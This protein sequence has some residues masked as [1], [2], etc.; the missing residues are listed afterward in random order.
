MKRKRIVLVVYLLLSNS[1][2]FCQAGSIEV[3]VSDTVKLKV[4]KLEYSIEAS[5][6]QDYTN[7]VIY[8]STQK[9]ITVKFA[10]N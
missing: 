3:E 6:N 2:I 1:C 8:Y 10:A 5:Q 4:S 9:A 7:Q